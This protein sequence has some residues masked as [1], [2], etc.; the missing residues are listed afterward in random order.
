[1]HCIKFP[2][3]FKNVR[4]LGANWAR[5][6]RYAMFKRIYFLNIWFVNDQNWTSVRV[7]N[8]ISLCVMKTGGDYILQILVLLIHG[9]GPYLN[10]FYQKIER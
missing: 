8:E 5:Q 4:A 10:F 3:C 1:M 2:C 6:V 9:H 7:A